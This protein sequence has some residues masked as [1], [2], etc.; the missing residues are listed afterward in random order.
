MDGAV[1]TAPKGVLL[2]PNVDYFGEGVFTGV[3]YR[4]EPRQIGKAD[5]DDDDKAFAGKRLFD[6]VEPGWYSRPAGPTLPLPGS[7]VFDFKR[8]CDFTEVDV[9]SEAK[10]VRFQIE[11]SADHAA[12]KT[13]YDSG[14]RMISPSVFHRLPFTAS[15][16]YLRLKADSNGTLNIPEV[17]VW[18]TAQMSEKDYADAGMRSVLDLAG[19]T[20]VP[21]IPATRASDREYATWAAKLKAV[22]ADRMPAVWSNAFPWNSLALQPILPNRALI[23]QPIDAV[24]CRNESEPVA[25]YLTNTSSN[26]MRTLKVTLSA[27]RDANGGEAGQITGELHVFAVQQSKVFGPTPYAL[28]SEHNKPGR[29][30][31]RRYCLNAAQIMDFPTIRLPPAGSAILW[32]KL[33]TDQCRPGKYSAVL[34]C[35]NGP[36]VRLDVQVVDITLPTPKVWVNYWAVETNMAPFRAVDWVDREAQVRHEMGMT[37]VDGWPEGGTAAAALY[38][39]NPQTLFKIWGMGNYGH[40]LWAV[41]HG[42]LKFG[43]SDFTRDMRDDLKNIVRAHANAARLFKL[44]YSQWFL[45]A[46][47]EPNPMCLPLFGEM[48]KVCKEADPNVMLYANPC[49]WLGLPD[50]QVEDDATMYPAMKDWYSSVAVDFCA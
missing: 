15:G 43:I 4:Y 27:F 16:R 46:A 1:A 7:V 12:W 45:E 32:V 18:G 10:P 23:N 37:V 35:Q 13:V 19:T 25:V 9:L 34:S 49:G 31:L 11:V 17:W 48:A 24:M 36:S 44:D 2:T 3:T 6:G 42:G 38:K 8:E 50:R 21:G 22:H 5:T 30:V 29:D 20:G 47:D 28:I 33:R 40:K 14:A 26:L 39:I 41:G